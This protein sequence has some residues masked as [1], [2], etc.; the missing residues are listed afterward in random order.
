MNGQNNYRILF[1]KKNG[2][3][4]KKP[5]FILKKKAGKTYFSPL[6]RS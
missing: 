6:K 3:V 5:L 1:M 2:P 4:T